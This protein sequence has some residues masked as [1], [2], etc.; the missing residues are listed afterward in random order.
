MFYISLSTSGALILEQF[1]KTVQAFEV[2]NTMKNTK[3][4]HKIILQ[5][6]LKIKTTV[7][8]NLLAMK[9]VCEQAKHQ[10]SRSWKNHAL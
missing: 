4:H 9:T 10:Q 6:K 3:N 7:F 5:S 2:E 1:P 8:V